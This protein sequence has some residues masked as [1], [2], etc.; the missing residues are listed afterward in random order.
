MGRRRP[1]HLIGAHQVDGVDALEVVEVEGVQVPGIGEL[2]GAGVV[3]EDV[4]AAPALERRAHQPTAVPVVRDIGAAE[5]GLGPRRRA[6]RRRLLGLLLAA[7]VVDDHVAALLGQQG[8]RGG[9]DAGGRAG[10]DRDLSVE[11]QD[12]PPSPEPRPQP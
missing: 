8:R 6:S 2:G 5:V 3:D 1:D 7:R 9:T 10:D 11:F 12:S 4:E